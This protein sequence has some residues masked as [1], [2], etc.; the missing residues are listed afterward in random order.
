MQN[1]NIAKSNSRLLKVVT[2]IVEISKYFC[3]LFESLSWKQRKLTK[4]SDVVRSFPIVE[5]G[6]V[7]L[8]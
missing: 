7:H 2:K 5:S 4:R 8:P 6:N 1:M 3:S